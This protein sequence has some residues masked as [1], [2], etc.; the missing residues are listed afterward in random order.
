MP[1]VNIIFAFLIFQVGIR[2]WFRIKPQP[3]PFGW[4]WLLENPWRKTYRNPELTAKQCGIKPTDTVLEIGCG[5]GLFTRALAAQ[6][7]RL[8][9]QDLEPKYLAETR[10][11]TTD[12]PHV[13]FLQGDVCALGLEAVADVIV[14]ISVLP[15]IPQP[16]EAL[17][18]C[19]KALK[20]GGRIIIS[21]ELFEPEYVL[22]QQTDTWA[23]AAGLGKIGQEGNIWVYLNRYARVAKT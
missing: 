13:E 15:E 14:L 4:T 3:I 19:V 18:A 7:A 20:P 22:S 16:V 9:A 1:L 21:Q 2:I 8:I 5:S 6:C 11:K 23:K 10:A 12:L 17:K